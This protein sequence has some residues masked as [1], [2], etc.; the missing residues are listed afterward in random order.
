MLRIPISI[1]SCP[2]SKLSEKLQDR[3]VTVI[4]PTIWRE[5]KAQEAKAQRGEVTCQSSMAFD[6]KAGTLTPVLFQQTTRSGMRG[7]QTGK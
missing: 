4:R 6:G 3:I 1:Y 2:L 5:A 7:N